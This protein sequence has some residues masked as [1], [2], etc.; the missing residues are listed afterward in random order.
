MNK[1]VTLIYPFDPLGQKVGGVETFI[2]GFIKYA[3]PELDIEHIGITTS[4]SERAVNVWKWINID[5]FCT[6]RPMC[7]PNLEK[8][9]YNSRVQ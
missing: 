6:L 4:L 3:P 8:V 9:C 7:P 1:K 5:Y 2:R